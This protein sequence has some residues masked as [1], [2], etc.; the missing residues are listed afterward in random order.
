MNPT[1]SFQRIVSL[2][3]LVGLACISA[4]A[5]DVTQFFNLQAGWN[6]IYLEVEPADNTTS[7]L[8]S[9]RPVSS[10]WTRAERI[11]SVDF[12]QD[13]SEDAFNQAGWLG[14]FHPSRPEA[15]L[16]NL[17]AVHA[18]RAYLIKADTAFTL[19][20]TGRPS[21]RQPGWAPDKFNLRG[22][23]IDAAAPP[24]F[25]GFFRFSGA[26]FDTAQDRL[27]GVYRMAVNGQWA[28]VGNGD[29]MRNGEACWVFCQ[30]ASEYVAP[31]EVTVSLGDGLDYGLELDEL[32]VGLRNRGTSAQALT[33]RGLGGATA[34]SVRQFNPTVGYVWSALPS[35]YALNLGG[36]AT[37]N[38]RLALRRSVLTSA[39]YAAVLEIRDG[40][41]TRHWLPVSGEKLLATA[42]ALRPQGV[43]GLHAPIDEAKER[44]GLW[45]GT[46]TINAVGEAH[47]ANPTVPTPTKSE[48]NLRLLI[49]VDRDGQTRLLKEVIQMWRDGTYT[50]DATGNRVMEQPG[51]YVLLT[52]ETRIGLFQGA[53][54]RDG[55]SV[56]RRI[57][58]IGFD[59]PGGPTNNFLN[60]S[61]FFTMGQTL[62]GTLSQGHDE[63][64]NPFKH[65]YHPDHDNLTARFDGP[66]VEAYAT[67]RQIEL[68]ILATPPPGTSAPD[69]GY[70]TIGGNFRETISGLH[71]TNL[72]VRG[73]FVLRRQSLIADLN[74]SPTP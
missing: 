13:A 66:A 48:F 54:V 62:S 71:K 12:I 31:L 41:G 26:H 68:E 42:G 21:I 70:N 14:W 5:Q 19:S 64:T 67:T 51:Q 16:G 39:N 33:L 17:F 32:P 53:G 28:A 47:A 1:P 46:A 49:H 24:T 35:P 40:A 4:R 38:L 29:V 60:L 63:P 7:T 27:R 69:Y 25:K 73:T 58:T 18:N 22:F 10:V 61:G 55:E 34:L 45:L 20:V 52:D 56:G 8:F 23:P 6:S 74:P 50:N 72:F 30:G 3:A 59:F 11:S 65:K 43:P 9:G 37:E 36:G 57:S 15:F 2:V 44:A